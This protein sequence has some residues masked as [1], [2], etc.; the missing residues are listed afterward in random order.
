MDEDSLERIARA[1]QMPEA[2]AAATVLR[3]HS[4]R[5]NS[6]VRA[7]MKTAAL[8]GCLSGC[9]PTACAAEL[10]AFVLRARH[11]ARANSPAV[12]QRLGVALTFMDMQPEMRACVDAHRC[13]ERAYACVCALQTGATWRH[14]A[15]ERGCTFALSSCDRGGEMK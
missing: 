15:T 14:D 13:A 6:R 4:A 1:V 9:T 7:M 12:Y 3:M 11:D 8:Q 5:A 10:Y 2:E